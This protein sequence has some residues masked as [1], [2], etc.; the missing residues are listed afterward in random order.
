MRN[1]HLG[2]NASYDASR[3]VFKWQTCS[4]FN[5]TKCGM[6]PPRTPAVTRGLYC[7]VLCNVLCKMTLKDL[8]EPPFLS[9]WA[10]HLRLKHQQTFHTTTQN[11]PCRLAKRTPTVT[12]HGAVIYWEAHDFN[13][14]KDPRNSVREIT[15]YYTRS[16]KRGWC[17][18]QSGY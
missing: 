12:M 3:A 18:S 6:F 1:Q 16:K 9:E 5:L 10:V 11:N 2:S 8:C 13:T 14:Q 17:V 15:L 4:E 7:G